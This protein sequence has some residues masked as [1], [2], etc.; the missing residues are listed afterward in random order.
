M[1]IVLITFVCFVFAN[2]ASTIMVQAES[3]NRSILAGTFEA[4]YALFWIYAAKYSLSTSP[5]EI[6]ALVIGNF[7]GAWIGT[8]WG[9]KWIK[10]HGDVAT[11]SRI[12]EVEAALLLAEQ[13]LHELDDEIAH[14]HDLEGHD[15]DPSD[16]T[17]PDDLGA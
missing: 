16:E 2:I 15:D 10:D 8:K 13:A 17:N 14:H 5:K 11:Q 12:E 4:I 6:I 7:F 1:W 3:R 9:E